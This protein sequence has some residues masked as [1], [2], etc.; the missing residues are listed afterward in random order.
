MNGMKKISAEKLLSEKSSR[1]IEGGQFSE[2][3]Y[4]IDGK[5]GKI[6]KNEERYNERLRECQS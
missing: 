4:K 2:V 5:Q 1:N 6:K 3:V